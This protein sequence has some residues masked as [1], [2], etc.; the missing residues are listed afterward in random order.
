MTK[1]E[2]LQDYWFQHIPDDADIVFRTNNE[3]RIC[4]T[5]DHSH[6]ILQKDEDG[7]TKLVID[8]VP[9]DFPIMRFGFTDITPE[10]IITGKTTGYE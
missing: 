3:L 6:M 1:K 7:H 4:R 8:A 10:F 9:L 2:L 5:L